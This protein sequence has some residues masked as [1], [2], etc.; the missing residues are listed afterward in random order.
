MLLNTGFVNIRSCVPT[1]QT[2]NSNLFDD[3]LKT[4]EESDFITPHTLVIEAQKPV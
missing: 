2:F 3:C 1:K 4:E